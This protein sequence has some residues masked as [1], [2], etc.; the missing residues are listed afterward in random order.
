MHVINCFVAV[1]N[2]RSSRAKLRPA[3]PPQMPSTQVLLSFIQMPGLPT[4]RLSTYCPT[5][6]ACL[7]APPFP[8]WQ[9]VQATPSPNKALS[10][11]DIDALTKRTQDGGTEVVQV[12]PQLLSWLLDSK[13]PPFP[14]L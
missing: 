7:L 6:G 8:R 14:L 5:L 13:D 3:A 12:R 10:E 2:R 4:A 9:A 11:E 1:H